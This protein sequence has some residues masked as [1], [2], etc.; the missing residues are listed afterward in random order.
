[1]KIGVLGTGN[2][3]GALV[4]GLLSRFGD[5]IEI[6]AYDANETKASDLPEAVHFVHPSQWNTPENEAFDAVVCAVKPNDMEKALGLFPD[7]SARAFAGTIWI[8]VAAGIAL[9]SLA[10]WIGT[11]KK[12]CRV[13][14]NTPALIGRGVCAFAT[15]P[16]CDASDVARIESILRAAGTALH[17][18]EKLMNAITGVSG[19]GPAYV[20][21]FIESLIE[22]GIGEGLP[23]DVARTCAAETVAGAAEMVAQ[24]HEHVASLRQR[25]MSPGGTTVR[26]VQQLEKHGLRNAVAQAVHAAT[27]R[28]GE[29]GNAK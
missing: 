5:A 18:S 21:L 15:N 2:M 27:E 25:V 8:S 14:P 12:I 23:P 6:W 3:G 26:G 11:Q 16:N 10:G 20:Y 29:L 19:S 17:V 24:S 4:Q 22:A 1:M 28:A 13:M 7:T 9:G